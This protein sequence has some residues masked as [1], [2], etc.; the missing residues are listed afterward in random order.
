MKHKKKLAD[1]YTQLKYKTSTTEVKIN[2]GYNNIMLWFITAYLICDSALDVYKAYNSP[3]NA[4]YDPTPNIASKLILGGMLNFTRFLSVSNTST[5]V[6]TNLLPEQ[7]IGSDAVLQNVQPN[8][9]LNAGYIDY[10]FNHIELANTFLKWLE[11]KN[12]LSHYDAHFSIKEEKV[13]KQQIDYVIRLKA[14]EYVALFGTDS[15]DELVDANSDVLV[16]EEVPDVKSSNDSRQILLNLKSDIQNKPEWFVKNW[17]R[18]MYKTQELPTLAREI[19][20]LVE[21]AEEQKANTE[22]WA[23]IFIKVQQKLNHAIHHPSSTR[24]GN[25]QSFYRELYDKIFEHKFQVKKVNNPG[26]SNL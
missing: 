2:N 20:N 10:H 21:N 6:T 18:T 24:T 5:I 8:V 16:A 22:V 15:F 4:I 25:T 17:L 11:H 12:A 26:N 19:V 1:E 23:E 7:K 14:G 3:E 9:N 13:S